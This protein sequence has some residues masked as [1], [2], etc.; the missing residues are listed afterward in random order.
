MTT[1]TSIARAR[2]YLAALVARD[3]V[4]VRATLADD[5]T[6]HGPYNDDVTGADDYV[7]FLERTF[8]DLQDYEMQI[9]AVWGHE[10]RV[11]AELAETVMIG[12]RRL[13]TDEAIVFELADKAI[14]RVSVFLRR[15]ITLDC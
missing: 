13:R 6:R 1:E 4:A 3:W 7:A 8:A 11:C 2:E 14:R 9:A 10:D 5:V 12:G 15:S